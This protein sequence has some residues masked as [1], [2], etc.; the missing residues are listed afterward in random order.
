MYM[1][2]FG[3]DTIEVNFGSDTIGVFPITIVFEHECGNADSILWNVQVISQSIETAWKKSTIGLQSGMSFVQ[4][5]SLLNQSITP[6]NGVTTFD[7]ALMHEQTT[8]SIDSIISDDCDILVN[9]VGD[10]IKIQYANCKDKKDLQTNIHLR[11]VIGE[12]LRPWVRIAS[13][14]SQ[15]PCIDPRIQNATDTIDLK[16]YGCE[17]T[18]LSIGKQTIQLIAV[19]PSSD[20]SM[21]NVIYETTMK[22]PIH[23]RCVSTVGQVMNSMRIEAKEAGRHQVSIPVEFISSGIY[24]L[25]FESDIYAVSSLFMIME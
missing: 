10:S 20:Q 21:V 22:M 17:L 24:A 7:I 1:D 16:A 2:A 25:L 6:L 14:S 4:T 9:R 19:I 11:S 5:F 18:T 3:M 23:I 8:L 12:T 15:D 13:F